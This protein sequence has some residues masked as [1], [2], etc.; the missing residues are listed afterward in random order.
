[1]RDPARPLTREEIVSDEIR[2]LIGDMLDTMR[3]APG[4]GLAAPQ[5]GLPLQLAV[6]E[7]RQELLNT[8]PAQELTE[9]ERVPV[10]FH[11]I[12]NLFL[13]PLWLLSGALFIEIVFNRPGIGKLVFDAVISRNYPVVLGGVL[14]TTILFVLC[15][16]VADLVAALLDPRLRDT[17]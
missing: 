8:L 11:A 14:I 3:D 7:D 4:V 17:L 1:M 12:I 16:L 6:I 10:S 9:K 5:V 2:K 15:T 13:I